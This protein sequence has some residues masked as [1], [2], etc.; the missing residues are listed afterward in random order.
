MAE[1]KVVIKSQNQMSSGIKSAQNEL[2]GFGQVADKVGKTLSKAF[3]A[4]AV[5]FSLK[6]ISDG[7]ASAFKDF[8]EADRKYKQLSLTLGD[9]KGYDK[10]VS[11][12]NKLQ[13]ETLSS[14][15]SIESMVSELAGLGKS[16]DEIEKISTAAV[17]LSNV[18]GQ[19]LNTAMNSLMK[20]TQGSAGSLAKYGIGVENLTKEQLQNGE[21]LDLVIEKFGELSKAMSDQSASQSLKN[22]K[23]TLGDI[24]QGFGNVI[25]EAI[26][27]M[28]H[29]IDTG[30]ADFKLKFDTVI[31][32][33]VVVI[34]NLPE[35][36]DRAL[37]LIKDML[38]SL[39]NYENLKSMISALMKHLLISVKLALENIG[40]LLSLFFDAIP[41]T[42]KRVMDGIFNYVMYIVTNVCDDIGLDLTSLINSIGKWLLESPI[43]QYV[44]EILS[45]VI[46][47]IRLV[48]A[49]MQN[50]PKMFKLVIDNIKPIL[51]GL[52]LSIEDI[53]GNLGGSI[54]AFASTAKD[55]FRY[56]GDVLKATFSWD[57]I[58]QSALSMIEKF[59]NF[60][61]DS[62]NNLIP[63]WMKKLGSKVGLD[64]TGIN[65][66]SLTDGANKSPY[67]SIQG[68]TVAS[69]QYQSKNTEAIADITESITKQ[70][71][72][73]LSPAF[74]EYAKNSSTTIGQT[75]ATWT[76]KSSKEYLAQS[77]KSFSS[78][79]E[80][81]SD[82]GKDFIADNKSGLGDIFDNLS[83]I[84][85]KVFGDDIG[86][87]AEWLDGFI[88]EQKSST[89]PTTQLNSYSAGSSSSSGSE[90]PTA[91]E[92]FQTAIE[93][94]FLG[95]IGEAGEV[96]KKLATNMATMGPVLGAIATALEYVLEGFGE[97]VRPVLDVLTECL[98]EPLREVGRMI[99]GLLLPILQDLMPLFQTIMQ[100]TNELTTSIGQMLKPIISIISMALTPVL[101]ILSN[102][103]KALSPVI[104]TFAV[105][106][107]SV[108][109]TIQWIIQSFQHG[110][111]SLFN[112][113]A[114][115][116][117]FGAHPFSALRMTDPGSAGSFTSFVGGKLDE[118]K[119]NLVV[120]SNSTVSGS[121]STAMAVQNASYSGGGSV[122]VNVY[123]EGSLIGDDGMGKLASIIK[124]EL[125]AQNYYG[126]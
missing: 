30:L 18:T 31:E 85:D 104:E 118:L 120:A 3:A 50:I 76:Q 37:S 82:W 124:S 74:E 86:A 43:G 89:L 8:E 63:D 103:F 20:T 69:N 32:G 110:V 121:S 28:L 5:L 75:L 59:C 9:S 100:V 46:N 15:G 73:L 106:I 70:F 4:T 2:S 99:G 67:D 48:G 123:F 34:K 66:V 57:N 87:F 84:G 107:T 98:I 91:F 1:A 108:T 61:I 35:V 23:D 116:S 45:N 126:V 71:K 54:S 40:N 36:I 21:A 65:R 109:A 51:K 81:L 22:I 92:K 53:F 55:T 24:K 10:A 95:S 14:K 13:R 29:T 12:I 88:Q 7:C 42:V 60:F 117:V 112:A 122:T 41:N 77:A 49:L 16:G 96:T 111:A 11:A 115:I 93:D 113:L 27:P 79:G 105:I 97:V 44:D 64:I 38:K 101:N 62:I 6:K 19:D 47:G 52:W 78:I 125:I 94:K 90:E 26:G 102:A 33:V 114:D 17:Y 25:S 83:A 58:K 119:A 39:F 72:E 68:I 80:F 56:V